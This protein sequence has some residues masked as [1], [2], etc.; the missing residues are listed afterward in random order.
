VLT[1]WLTA[2]DGSQRLPLFSIGPTGAWGDLSW[3]TRWG[4][5]AC[6]MYEAS[7][8][9]PLPP[10]FAHPLLRRGTLVELMDGSYRVGSPLIMSEPAI[11]TGIDDPW[12]ITCT[13][14]GREVEGD[15][16][17]YAFDGSGFAT[18]VPSTAVD[19]AI[20]APRNLRWAGRD[21][22]VPSSA[23]VTGSS[24]DAP[25]TVGGLLT[26]VAQST[27][28]RWGVFGDNKVGFRADPTTPS[29][30]VTPGSAQLGTADDDY[31]TVVYVVHIDSNTSAYARVS[32]PA[33]T[34]ATET[35]F[36]RREYLVDLTTLGAIPT[37]TAQGYADGILARSKGRLA[38]T[39]GL[40][41]TSNEILTSG[42]VSASLSKVAEDVSTGCMV[43][44]HGIFDDLL[45]FSGQTWLDIVIGEAKLT[46]GT[47]LIDLSP[48][49]LAARDLASIVESVT[50]RAA[51]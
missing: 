9:M 22:T 46:D 19:Q 26:A 24:S 33:T 13:G 1:P 10:G 40:T 17:F 7:W 6:G 32:S 14:I 50:G 28:N 44:L 47:D 49:G 27:G 35:K 2:V 21:A 51:A 30:H 45:E 34:S 18:L 36:A 31:A 5:G 38:W 41:L 48:I 42:G 12:Q 11:G 23:L 15:S 16:S 4:D 43:R 8:T 39:N 20:A 25:M 3:M 37:A 29:Y